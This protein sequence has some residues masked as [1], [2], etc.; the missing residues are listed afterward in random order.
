MQQ[1]FIPFSPFK[2]KYKLDNKH[3]I[4]DITILQ[5]RKKAKPRRGDSGEIRFFPEMAA[6]SRVAH[7]P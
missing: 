1:K 3:R 5:W 2:P 7:I 4:N 6:F